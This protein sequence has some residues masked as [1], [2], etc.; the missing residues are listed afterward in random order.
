MS[1]GRRYGKR[2]RKKPRIARPVKKIIN[3]MINRKLGGKTN[4]VR[5]VTVGQ[6]AVVANQCKYE[7]FIMNRRDYVEDHVARQEVPYVDVDGSGVVNENQSL[8]DGSKTKI[9]NAKYVINLRNNGQIPVRMEAHWYMCK[10]DTEES[11]YSYY[12][13]QGV[14]DD[15][16]GG[17]FAVTDPRYYLY[18]TPKINQFWKHF[19]TKKCV[20]NG[21]DEITLYMNQRKPFYYT[22]DDSTEDNYVK[23][24]TQI[25]IVRFEGVTAHDITTT[26]N[27]GL[28]DGLIDY[29]MRS[30]I[31]FEI[32]NTMKFRRI[33]EGAGDFA[34]LTTPVVTGMD[35]EEI[36]EDP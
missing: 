14:L 22:T 1:M 21:G 36:K 18:D 24:F 29:V 7:Q 5:N 3:G 27:V 13:Q 33:L 10:K 19:K 30:H 4:T 23:G 15:G 11:V 6:I 32:G 28:G 8:M 25:C 9:L 12:G 31:K 17:N 20:L 35:V 26:A 2:L 16:I 34:E